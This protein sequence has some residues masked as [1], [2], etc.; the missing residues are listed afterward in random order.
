MWGLVFEKILLYTVIKFSYSSHISCLQ[1]TLNILQ[2]MYNAA[3]CLYNFWTEYSGVLDYYAGTV[4]TATVCNRLTQK[5]RELFKNPTKIEEIQGKKIIDRKWTIKTCLLRDSN[6]NI[7]VWKLHPVDGVLL[8]VCILSLPLR[9]SKV[10]VPLGHPVCVHALQNA[11][12][13]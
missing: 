10:P 1:C 11:T 4:P 5:K 12:E 7:N 2:S 6:P 13:S 9:I 3:E 8:H